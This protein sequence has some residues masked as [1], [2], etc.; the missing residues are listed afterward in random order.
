VG[1]GFTLAFFG[2]LWAKF[3]VLVLIL[4][5]VIWTLL[6][7]LNK[8]QNIA[9]EFAQKEKEG[10]QSLIILG[11]MRSLLQ[12]SSKP[13]Q[14]LPSLFKSINEKITNDPFLSSRNFK[15]RYLL[16]ELKTN[17]SKVT[18]YLEKSV[19]PVQSEVAIIEKQIKS[20]HKSV[21]DQSNL[22]LDP[23][24]DSYYTMDLMLLTIPKQYELLNDIRSSIKSNIQ[25][26]TFTFAV[27]ESE[28]NKQNESINTIIDINPKFANSNLQNI[29][30][31]NEQK[32]RNLK[33]AIISN[34]SETEKASEVIRSVDEAQ[35][36]NTTAF[37][38]TA[39]TMKNL[40]ETRIKSFEVRRDT[41]N[42]I[43]I[44]LWGFAVLLCFNL[45]RK[46]VVKAFNIAS[47]LDNLQTHDVAQL[48]I[49]ISKLASGDFT[50][51]VVPQYAAE[52]M[53]NEAKGYDELAFIAKSVNR[54]AG[55][56][57]NGIEQFTK[58][59][60]EVKRANDLLA[61]S[62]L[63][64]RSMIEGLG[65]GILITDHQDFITYANQ[66]ITQL[67]NKECDQ[68]IGQPISSIIEPNEWN[69]IKGR[70]LNLETTNSRGYE[71][72]ISTQN[73]VQFHAE[74]IATPLP[75]TN[76]GMIVAILDISERKVVEEQLHFQA[77]H[78]SLTGLPNRALFMD[79]VEQA[80]I[81]S[82]KTGK[83]FG[84][85]FLD[86]DNF[87]IV[88][89][90]L[91]H[92]VGDELLK[93]IAKRLQECVRGD[94]TIARLGGDEFT[95]L[96][97]GLVDDK[98]VMDIAS[99]IR[100]QFSQPIVLGEHNILSGGSL[101]I[102]Y[103]NE[104]EDISDIL[105]NADIAMYQAKANGKHRHVVFDEDMRAKAEQRLQ[106]EHDLRHALEH[107]LLT[108][109]Y[110]PIIDLKT[111]SIAEV[112]ALVRWEHPTLGNIEPLRFIPIAE[113]SGLI[114]QLGKYVMQHACEFGVRWN[115]ERA[116]LPPILIGVNLSAIQLL[117]DEIV[118]TV[119][120]ILWNTT[121][122]GSQLKLEITE[123]MMM[124]DPEKTIERLHQL[125]R[126]GVQLAMDDFGTGY[127]SMSQLKLMPIDTLKIDRTFIS[128]LSDGKQ[129]AAIVKAII[130]MAKSLGLSVTSEGIETKEQ[131]D[132]LRALGCERVQGY[133]Y[134]A[135]VDAENLLAN[136]PDIHHAA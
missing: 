112:E 86:L 47:H 8:E 118:D 132:A 23:D 82:T 4:S 34:T 31:D 25:A 101:G 130:S 15:D 2:R 92:G 59:Q 18:A 44:G 105:R 116:T 60:E 17:W 29:L 126:L 106:L 51:K 99:R 64:F 95:I 119:R 48:T 19:A 52:Q 77:L 42:F 91:G 87:K 97:E 63:Q 70:W 26:T 32:I 20:V 1:K 24:L 134:S 73:S 129:D 40:L 58:S 117:S 127:S 62:E 83:F 71:T 135:A 30:I 35:K 49:G 88:N 61:Q 55:Q 12:L 5:S 89:D 102:A 125:R 111:D 124:Q 75:S 98:P 45:V 3:A 38:I 115:L 16:T 66:K 90:S 81:R 68:L 128:K 37:T 72:I 84:L 65:E 108:I 54:L 110:Q 22:I 21:G 103:S 11:E 46:I 109:K 136:Y 33:L 10:T 122:P 85:I 107:N 96:I 120:N 41:S 123:S 43:A 57:Q 39:D 7:L 6:V 76:A 80:K 79:R 56:T 93:T 94:D 78:D 104:I 28:V 14:R 74:I 100:L 113:E 13:D 69:A 36:T 53:L 27:L 114:I 9:I 121:L 50:Y 133:H 67:I 131:L